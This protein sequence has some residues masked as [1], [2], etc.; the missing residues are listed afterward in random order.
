MQRM[1]TLSRS[2]F[3]DLSSL[4]SPVRATDAKRRYALHG[5]EPDHAILIEIHDKKSFDSTTVNPIF[6]AVSVCPP[7]VSVAED[8]EHSLLRQSTFSLE[9]TLIACNLP[10]FMILETI[11]SIVWILCTLLKSGAPSFR[12]QPRLRSESANWKFVT[13]IDAFPSLRIYRPA[14]M[15]RS[16][17]RLLILV[18]NSGIS[19]SV[20]CTSL[21][22]SM[23]HGYGG[24]NGKSFR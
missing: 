4:T 9:I 15:G 19:L 8:R 24:H 3:C 23:R 1:Q 21:A 7:R 13:R 5:F 16:A 14:T 17:Q 10:I 22:S 11:L 12:C 18:A 20:R 6:P 2:P